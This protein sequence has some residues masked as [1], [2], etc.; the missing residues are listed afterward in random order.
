M[1]LIIAIYGVRLQKVVETFHRDTQPGCNSSALRCAAVSV[2]LVVV[3]HFFGTFC[4]SQLAFTDASN[5]G[6]GLLSKVRF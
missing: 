4:F 1:R 3:V 6:S 5:F 2:H